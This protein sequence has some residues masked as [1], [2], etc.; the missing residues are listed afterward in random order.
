MALDLDA[1]VTVAD[2]A[3]VVELP[4]TRSRGSKPNPFT[5]LIQ[6]AKADGKDRTLP[7]AFSLKPQG[8]KEYT[9]ADGETKTRV[10]PSEAQQVENLLRS[11]AYSEGVGLR[12]DHADKGDQRVISFRVQKKRSER[13]ADARAARVAEQVKEEAPKPKPA[14]TKK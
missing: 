11:A 10:I 13:A 5:K 4:A 1:L 12:V 8:T 6:A 9:T 7:Q 14:P 3:K 2:S